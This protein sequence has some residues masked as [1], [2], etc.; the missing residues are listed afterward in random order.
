MNVNM[1]FL[2]DLLSS[3]GRRTRGQYLFGGKDGDKPS[4]LA[5]LTSVCETLMHPGGEASQILIAQEALERYASLDDS[6]RVAFFQ[7]LGERYA[8]EPDAIHQAYAAYRDTGDNASLQRLFSAC[9]PRR[10][11]LLRRLN[12]CPGGTY[13][14]VKM[15]ADLLRCLKTHPELA[16]L[17][18]DFEHLFASWFN[19]GFLVL[20]SIDWNTPAAVLEK[21]IHYEAV[22]AIG[23]WSDLR[24]RLDP[25]DRHCYAFFHPATGDEPL[26]FVEVALCKG[27]PNSIQTILEGG[28]DVRPEEAD[29]AAF[30]SISNCQAGL[31]GISFGNFLIKQVVQELKRELPNL[32][33]FVTL[34][35]V[36]GFAKWLAAERESGACQLTDEVADGLDAEG[37]VENPKLREKLTPE[38][39][40]LAAHYLIDAKRDNG[41][42]LDPVAR[43]HLGN[44]ASLHRLNWP[45][46][47]SENGRRQSHGLMVN[48]LY[49]LDRIEQNHEAFSREGTVVCTSDIRR[50]AKQGRSRCR[51]G[52]RTDA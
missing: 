5:R 23:D 2:Q 6:D 30:Y 35:P 19:R 48:Y 8:A 3:I 17:D 24:R 28:D 9:E 27:I 36:P 25:E 11:H 18:A 26:I 52:S 40:G 21:I 37:W 14:L 20:E 46:D 44:G 33:K 42:P 16:P 43:F 50:D 51:H 47:T 45:G 29:T 32:E 15:R 49:E 12:L 22:H 41:L 7:L 10:Q 34:S 1:N 4:S 39:R 31:R 13:E 38:V